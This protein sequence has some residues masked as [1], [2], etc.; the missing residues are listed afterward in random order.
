MRR[1]PKQWPVLAGALLA[2]TLIM[3]GRSL[4]VSDVL[5][6][7]SLDATDARFVIQSTLTL[8]TARLGLQL[9]YDQALAPMSDRRAVDAAVAS[10][11]LRYAAEELPENPSPRRLGFGYERAVDERPES[12]RNWLKLVIPM[13]LIALLLAISPARW[14][15]GRRKRN[16]AAAPVEPDDAVGKRRSSMKIGLIAL[17]VGIA[18]G[19][20]GVGL[21]MT[22]RDADGTA[23]TMS[24]ASAPASAPAEAP[25][26]HPIVG[27]WRI[28]L[29][30]IRATY[31]FA[32]DGSFVVMFTG[33][34]HR[35]PAG[36]DVQHDAGGTWRVNGKEL[37]LSNTWSN[38]PLVIVGERETATIIA[39]EPD[40]MELE[41][42][43]RKG[44]REILTFGRTH[45]FVAGQADQTAI[46]GRWQSPQFT[47]DL[48]SG[49]EVVMTYGRSGGGGVGSRGAE[50][51]EGVWSQRGQTLTLRMDPPYVKSAARRAVDPRLTEP[52]EEEYDVRTVNESRL[53]LHRKNTP[54]G[55]HLVF[56]RTSSSA[57][58]SPP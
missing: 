24:P 25:P 49:G 57:A 5:R 12:F 19:A 4:W 21:Y 55:A 34:P 20:V 17:V 56:E 23:A 43:D 31:R 2:L 39:I 7:R 6:W 37:V 15:I 26:I 40:R 22:L 50:P 35:P 14:L 11:G 10:P 47:L 44:Q 52:R 33:M 9:E 8:R 46:V 1:K 29:G 38:T 41:H 13:W 54:P 16:D 42:A 51:R 27:M 30:G 3:A 28:D 32:N 36:Q 18:I 48:R 58:A 45:P 53:I